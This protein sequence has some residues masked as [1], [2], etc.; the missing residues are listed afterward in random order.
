MPVKIVWK[1]KY[2]LTFLA[3]ELYKSRIVIIHVKKV[4]GQID[5][6]VTKNHVGFFITQKYIFVVKLVCY[7]EAAASVKKFV[8]NRKLSIANQYIID[9]L[10]QICGTF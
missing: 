6:N 2:V 7:T 4:H 10:I 3:M 5:K 9:I 1:P 8:Q